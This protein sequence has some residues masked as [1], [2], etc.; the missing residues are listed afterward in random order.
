MTFRSLGGVGLALVMALATPEAAAAGTGP[1]PR[2]EA[3]RD[4]PP[5]A[6]VSEGRVL[7]LDGV[8]SPPVPVP[9]VADACCV[10]F[11]PDSNYLAFERRGGLRVAPHPR[12]EPPPRTPPAPRPSRG[13]GRAGAGRL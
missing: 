12:T 13:A 3:Y 11:S 2:A 9:G 8:G 1:A 10:A 6:Y 4:Q 7:V 5:L